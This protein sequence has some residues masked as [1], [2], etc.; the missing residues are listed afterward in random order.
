MAIRGAEY[1]VAR[2]IAILQANLPAELNLVDAEEADFV[3]ADVANARYY[4]AE[5]E[6]GHTPEFPAVVVDAK[7]TD[8]IALTTTT[9]SPGIDESEHE[10]VVSI[11]LANTE[12][13]S[14]S[15]LKKRVL[16]YARAIV[17]VLA[18]KNPTLTETVVSV[19]R[20]G[21]GAMLYLGEDNNDGRL[22]GCE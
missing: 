5:F 19:K 22:P 15:T 3:L 14:R 21:A 2:V 9:N 13:E 16:R 7:S 10:V 8:T 12:N 1:A 20:V 4:D 18:I 17:R 6:E 11:V